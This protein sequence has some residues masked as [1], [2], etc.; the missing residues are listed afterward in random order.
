MKRKPRVLVLWNQT[1][2]DV[3]EVWKEQ[4]PQA[5]EWNPE[6]TASEVGT[7]GEEMDALLTALRAEGVEVHCINV[8]DNIDKL[9]AALRLYEPDAVFNLVE[10]FYDDQNLEPNVA[11]LYELFDVPYTGSTPHCLA[12]CQRKVRTK[13]LLEDAGLPTSPYC[14]VEKEPVPDP[15]EL[16]LSYPLIVKPALEDASGG[17]EPE[18]VVH[19][20]ESLVERVRYLLTEFEQPALVEEYV[21]GREIHAAIIGNKNPEVLPLFEMEFDDSDIFEDDEEWRPQI[22]SYSAKWDPHSKSFYTMDAVVPPRDLPPE[23]EARI[24]DVALKAYR[25]MGCRDYAR[26]DMRVEEDGTPYILEVN[27]NPDL[28]DDSAFIMCAKAS[29]RTYGQTLREIAMMAANRYPKTDEAETPVE[30]APTDFLNRR[31]HKPKADNATD[32]MPSAEADASAD[33]EPGVPTA[34]TPAVRPVA[35]ETSGNDSDRP[36]DAD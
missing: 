1:E 23:V 21:E 14:V 18:S 10:F 33:A 11:A 30:G 5:L 8:E 2:E 24:K 26:V 34:V 6:Y 22:I 13:L 29:G 19:D 32:A 20:Y 17:I 9:I 4:G 12:A 16:E 36:T 35:P 28:A 7:V 27:P 15:E 3:Y 31:Y 25:V